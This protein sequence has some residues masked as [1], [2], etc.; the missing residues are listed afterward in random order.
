[1]KTITEKEQCW[2][3]IHNMV[4]LYEGYESCIS[5]EGYGKNIDS[6]IEYTY[7]MCVNGKKHIS[8]GKDIVKA[9]DKFKKLID[10]G[11]FRIKT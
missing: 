7:Y 10:D 11:S 6:I 8:L 9:I 1:M 2:K 4:G 3:D 5:Y